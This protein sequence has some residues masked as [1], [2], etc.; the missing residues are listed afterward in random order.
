MLNWDAIGAVGE[1]L[2]A[3]AVLLTLVYLANQIRQAKEVA[4]FGAARD[5]MNSYN[6]LNKLL[7]TDPT[8]RLA[9]EKKTPLSNDEKEL[10]YNFAIMFCNIWQSIQ[11]AHDNGQ[12]DESTYAGGMKDAQIEIDRWPNFRSAVERWMN[13]Y[14]E[15]SST[16]IFRQLKKS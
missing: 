13:T 2:G 14:P 6:D 10:I 12:T 8:L 16:A 9:L 3:V 15:V 4:R 7:V 5:I 1:I 11:A